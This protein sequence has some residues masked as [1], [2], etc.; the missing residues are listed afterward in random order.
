MYKNV[1]KALVEF[2]GSDPVL[3]TLEQNIIT[4]IQIVWKLGRMM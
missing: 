1:N 4:F 3:Q 2:A